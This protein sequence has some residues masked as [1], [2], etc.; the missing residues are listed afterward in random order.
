MR[1]TWIQLTM[2]YLFVTAAA[3]VLMRSAAIIPMPGLDYSHILHA[4][5]HLAILG[6]GYMAMFLLFIANFF[7][8]TERNGVQLKRLFWLT[9]LTIVGMF[10]SFSLQGYALFSIGFSTLQI[11]LSYWFAVF[12]WR[13]LGRQADNQ[14]KTI[15]SHLFAKA[16]L[17]SLV[18]SSIGPWML[19]VLSANHLNGTAWY[20]A[21]IY[22][23][24]HFQYN[25]WFTFGLI[26][27]LLRIL[28]KRSIRY[29]EKLVK[30]QFGLYAVSLPPSFLLSV[31]G[32]KTDLLWYTTAAIGA[33]LQ[34]AAVL[35]LIV[36]VYQM[37]SAI[38]NLFEGWAGKFFVLSF[39]ALLMK[40]TM[41][42]GSAVP[43]L[44]A[45]IYDSRSIVIGYLH[46][47]LLGFF[48]FFCISLFLQQ[49]WLSEKRK[50]ERIGYVLF[51]TGFMIN[52]L[53]L[54][55]QGMFDW[56]QV[57]GIAYQREWLWIAS[58]GMTVGVFMFWM[59]GRPR[60]RKANASVPHFSK[61][62]GRIIS[63]DV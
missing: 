17:I 61:L 54:F 44:S 8:N 50:V 53:V 32:L 27:V 12:V 60:V 21:A 28:E 34:W 47:T 24:L 42:I 31:L 26:A 19:A 49:G 57:S 43:G 35:L 9:Q 5:S 2:S 41:E 39:V 25:G 40:A 23:Y 16:S 37:R 51:L 30:L 38:V 7:N 4:H 56:I 10:V 45:L 3:G 36:I 63:R 48:S 33:L 1:K 55:L 14:K 62:P 15:I 11:L 46:L 29:P 52:E 22:F 59:K 13:H 6:W 18:V 58:M 20:D